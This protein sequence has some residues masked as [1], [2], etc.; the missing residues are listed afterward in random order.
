MNTPYFVVINQ[1]DV[2]DGQQT[3]AFVFQTPQ[4]VITWLWGR[5]L[6]DFDI[7]KVKQDNEIGRSS[8]VVYFD[9]AKTSLQQLEQLME[10]IWS[11]GGMILL[12]G[13]V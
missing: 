11:A 13:L 12:L 2:K 10:K 1:K 5:A 9:Y 4:Q 8:T 3:N 6:E 7:I